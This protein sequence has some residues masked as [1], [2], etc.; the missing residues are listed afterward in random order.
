MPAVTGN[1]VHT[2]VG[3]LR[4]SDLAEIGV[5]TAATQRF[6]RPLNEFLETEVDLTILYFR[7]GFFEAGALVAG[8]ASPIGFGKN[9]LAGLNRQGKSTQAHGQR[10]NGH[11]IAS[12]A[13]Q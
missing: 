12:K 6:M 9:V 13:V 2:G 10:Q 4:V 5:A 7:S 11:E 8:D 1:A 3:I